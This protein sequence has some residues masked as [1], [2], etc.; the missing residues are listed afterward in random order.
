MRKKRRGYK[1]YYRQ[2]KTHAERKANL[3]T[4]YV[5][6]RRRKLPSSWDDYKVHHDK[7]WKSKRRKKYREEGRGEKHTL[8]IEESRYSYTKIWNLEEYFKQHDIPYCLEKIREG[9]TYTRELTEQ[10]PDKIEAAYSWVYKDGRMVP[11]HP[12]GYYWTYK[13]VKT[14]CFETYHGS[15]VVGYQLTWWTNK[16]IG[17]QYILDS[18]CLGE[19]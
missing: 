10:V 19:Y 4:E 16:D 5:R 2:P 15:T 3:D 9:Y 18:V 1:N 8:T 17:V 11:R 13:T 14:G 12:I 6:P 7:C